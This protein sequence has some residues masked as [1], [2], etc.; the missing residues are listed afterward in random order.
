[1][2]NRELEDNLQEKEADWLSLENQWQTEHDEEVQALT[3]KNQQLT[4]QLENTHTQYQDYIE[5]Q[6][7]QVYIYIYIYIYLLLY[8]RTL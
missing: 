4:C 2:A 8:I 3:Q 1:M 6:Q 5:E 7:K